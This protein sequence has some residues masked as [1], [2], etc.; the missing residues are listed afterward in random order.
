M[1]RK[2]KSIVHYINNILNPHWKDPTTFASGNQL[3]DAL[4]LC[5]KPAW[6]QKETERLK[7][8]QKDKKA[9]TDMTHRA[10][11]YPCFRFLGLPAGDR[12]CLEIFRSPLSG[13]GPTQLSKKLAS[14]IRNR[15]IETGSRDQRR[16]CGLK[17]TAIKSEE[18]VIRVALPDVA[19]TQV[20]RLLQAELSVK[21]R[22]LSGDNS[23]DYA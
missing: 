5:R 4:L 20:D 17:T 6:T 19:D 23:V 2:V 15:M 18:T 21:S 22:I 12:G 1:I 8:K 13:S 9:A 16:L 7:I 10:F 11:E 3:S 14:E